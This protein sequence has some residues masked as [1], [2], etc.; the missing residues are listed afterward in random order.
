M[1]IIAQ[2][3][4]GLF[5]TSEKWKKLS[6]PILWNFISDGYHAKN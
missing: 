6:N 1:L 3:Y 5:G 4:G 2:L